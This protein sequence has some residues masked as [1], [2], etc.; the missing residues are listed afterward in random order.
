MVDGEWTPFSTIFLLSFLMILRLG[1]C[2][3]ILSLFFMHAL[4]HVSLFY[5]AHSLSLIFLERDQIMK[6]ARSFIC[7]MDVGWVE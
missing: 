4:E 1:L 2:F 3:F 6:N 7:G 5:I